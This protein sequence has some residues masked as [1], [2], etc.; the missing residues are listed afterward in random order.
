MKLLY[1]SNIE[2]SDFLEIAL[3]QSEFEL[4]LEKGI[5]QDYRPGIYND[6]NLNVFVR[7]LRADEDQ[8][9]DAMPFK[10]VAQRK[11]LAINE[12]EVAHE[13][14]EHTT[15]AQSEVLPDRVQKKGSTKIKDKIKPRGTKR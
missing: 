12:P 9:E 7:L 3:T 11:Y 6:Y 15:K 1:E 2:F 8:G 5:V 13:F 10:S 14:A 4:L